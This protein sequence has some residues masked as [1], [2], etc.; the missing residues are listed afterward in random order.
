MRIISLTAPPSGSAAAALLENA[1]LAANVGPLKEEIRARAAHWPP[2]DG[3]G[4]TRQRGALAFY[5][6][7]FASRAA[8]G[9]DERVSKQE[10]SIPCRP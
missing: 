2:L 1:S 8:A 4:A 10:R 9:E 6:R 7:T 5:D 3:G